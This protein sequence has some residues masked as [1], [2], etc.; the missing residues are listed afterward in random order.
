[1]DWQALDWAPYEGPAAAAVGPHLTLLRSAIEE[2]ASARVSAPVTLRDVA[3]A[4]GAALNGSAEQ[5]IEPAAL[6]PVATFELL[7]ATRRGAWAA[8]DATLGDELAGQAVDP[9]ALGALVVGSLDDA[10][11]AILGEGLNVGPAPEAAPDGGVPLIALRLSLAGPDEMVVG[12]VLVAE[13]PAESELVA[14][15]TA[16]QALQGGPAS[17]PA[18]RPAPVPRPAAEMPSPTRRLPPAS[19]PASR[20]PQAPV[21]EQ[22]TVRAARFEELAPSPVASAGNGIELLLGVN[23]QVTVEIGRAQLPIREILA[24]APG[25]I[26]ELDK[27]AGEQVDVLV[28]GHPIAQGEVVVVD[29][30]FG[31]RI[32]TIV[33]RRGRLPAAGAA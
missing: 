13:S 25:S 21:A 1:M 22:P 24:L 10:A 11:T 33:S 7:G 5:V 31:V 19:A 23:L 8:L 32:T 17:A 3:V 6:A 12:L 18:A 26:V 9:A 20:P 29:E 16:M 28:N 2:A 15:V 30:N 27:L 14:H 4:R